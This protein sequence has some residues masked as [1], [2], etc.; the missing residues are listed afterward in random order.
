MLSVEAN[1]HDDSS[2]A[3][4]KYT[5]SANEEVAVSFMQMLLPNLSVGGKTLIL[6]KIMDIFFSSVHVVATVDSRGFFVLSQLH[7]VHMCSLP[8]SY[9]HSPLPR[10]A[11]MGTYS[12]KS[13]Q[14]SPSYGFYYD[15]A[16]FTLAAQYDNTVRTVSLDVCAMCPLLVCTYRVFS[17]THNVSPVRISA[18][19]THRIHD[20]MRSFFLC[21]IVPFGDSFIV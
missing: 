12:S 6:Q 4:V 21:N 20:A 14:I 3:Q 13:G 7:R 19:F 9:L 2:T 17:P 11:G 16:E 1:A 18:C 8:S 10:T 15:P 5:R